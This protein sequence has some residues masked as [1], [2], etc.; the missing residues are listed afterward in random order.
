[1]SSAFGASDAA[2]GVLHPPSPVSRLPYHATS[3]V[4]QVDMTCVQR[5]TGIRNEKSADSIACV[6][7]GACPGLGYGYGWRRG[8]AGRRI[9]LLQFFVWLRSESGVGS[10]RTSIL[11]VA[12]GRPPMAMSGP[13]LVPGPYGQA[14]P[15]GQAFHA[16]GQRGLRGHAWTHC[17]ALGSGVAG[18][19]A[20]RAA[21][22][23]PAATPGSTVLGAAALI[24]ATAP[25]NFTAG[26]FRRQAPQQLLSYLRHA[27]RS[28][29]SLQRRRQRRQVRSCPSSDS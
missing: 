2:P 15:Y 28:P 22:P 13:P 5:W 11:A 8:A 26:S 1:M 19:A 24:D 18:M 14:Y 21:P 16:P 23:V 3:R 20:D 29:S 27:H 25:A 10:S 17:S 9:L 7:E 4:R 6:A 12:G